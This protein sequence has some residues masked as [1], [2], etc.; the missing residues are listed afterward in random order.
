MVFVIPGAD[1]ALFL[2]VARKEISTTIV[3]LV[4]ICYIGGDSLVVAQA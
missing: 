1:F 3:S 4:T 2:R